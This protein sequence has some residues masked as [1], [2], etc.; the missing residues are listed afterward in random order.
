[1]SREYKMISIDRIYLELFTVT[2][3][4]G[5]LQTTFSS[6]WRDGTDHTE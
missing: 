1:M 3:I 6:D 4:Q 2:A 5:N